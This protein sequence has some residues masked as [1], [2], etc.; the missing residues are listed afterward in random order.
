M[1]D[2]ASRQNCRAQ[3]ECIEHEYHAS[4]Q[5]AI[6]TTLFLIQ[7]SANDPVTALLLG[8]VEGMV[9]KFEQLFRRAALIDPGR[10]HAELCSKLV[11]GMIEEGGV[12][13]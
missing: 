4:H 1:P 2:S 6:G 3:S 9:G 12:P 5:V 13:C 8:L 11:Y 10:R 7:F